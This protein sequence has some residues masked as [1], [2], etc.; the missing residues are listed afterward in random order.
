MK[1]PLQLNALYS[2]P[3]GAA[4]PPWKFSSAKIPNKGFF[5][6]GIW[7]AGSHTPQIMYLHTSSCGTFAFSSV[8]TTTCTTWG[9]GNYTCGGWGVL[10]AE[11]V[12][13]GRSRPCSMVLQ[14]SGSPPL[15]LFYTYHALWPYGRGSLMISKL[16]LVILPLSWTTILA[17]VNVAN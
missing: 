6:S 5:W 4:V 9:H 2:R 17:S 13:R 10:R 1:N 7:G 11:P 12:M 8:T 15:K 14:A 16:P 3:I